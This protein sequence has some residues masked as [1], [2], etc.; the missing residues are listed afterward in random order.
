MALVA[1]TEF[2]GDYRI[3]RLLDAGGMGVV[4]EATQQN[5]GARWAVKVMRPELLSHTKA[6]GLIAFFCLTGRIYWEGGQQEDSSIDKRD[7]GD[8]VLH[9]GERAALLSAWRREERGCDEP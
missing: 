9:G 2:A 3:E 4:Y 7:D 8:A 5:T 1:G 6:L